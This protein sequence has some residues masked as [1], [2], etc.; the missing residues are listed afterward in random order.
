VKNS[1]STAT[2]LHIS[3]KST[4][5]THKPKRTTNHQEKKTF[6]YLKLPYINDITNL[7]IAHVYKSLNLPVRIYHKN[8]TLGNLLKPK[9]ENTNLTCN[10]TTCTIKNSK[11]CLKKNIVYCLTC[12]QCNNKYIGST[13]RPFHDRLNEH[14]KTPSKPI[15]NHLLFCSNTNTTP[16]NIDFLASDQDTL[17]LR[18][19][20]AFHINRLKPSLNTKKRDGE[21]DVFRQ[22]PTIT[23]YILNL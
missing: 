18:F 16:F 3:T 15:Y 20:E 1:L 14:L 21:F 6:Y 10:K 22:Q 9:N 11:I 7:K 17:S 2:L 12:K 23:I 13:I 4:K 8:I 5:N 19:H